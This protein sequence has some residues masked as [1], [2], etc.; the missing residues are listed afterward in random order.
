MKVL[1]K[2]VFRVFLTMSKLPLFFLY[3]I[4]HAMQTMVKLGGKNIFKATI[5]TKVAQGLH[6]KKKKSF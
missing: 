5:F 2:K 1:V 6:A 4:E 3:K